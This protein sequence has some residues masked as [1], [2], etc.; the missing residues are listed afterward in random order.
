MLGAPR[1][2]EAASYTWNVT[3]GNW[4]TPTSW[5]PTTTG[6]NGPLATDTVMFA[7]NGASA[8]STTVNNIV[9]AG[10]AGTVS[11][12]L[13]T[14][15]NVNTFQV[16]QIG[17]G[18][19]L[20]VSNSVGVGGFFGLQINTF[21]YLTGGGNLVASGTTNFT[22][23]NYGSAS[24][25]GSQGTLDLS[26][27][28]TF[29]YNNPTG[30]ISIA[31]VGQSGFTR[32][33]GTL[34]LAG[35][36]NNITAA[37]INVGTCAAAQ[38]GPNDNFYLGAGTNIINVGTINLANNK[39]SATNTFKGLT[40]GLKIRGVTGVDTDRANIILGNR[41]QSGTGT[42]AGSM[43]FNGY[44]V[45]IKANA[46]IVGT[47][48]S[49]GTTGDT[50]TGVFQF[51]T[52]TVD[53]TSVIIGA[54]VTALGA[55]NGTVTV[56]ANGT[57]VVGAGGLSLVTQTASGAATGNLNI[58]NGTVVCNGSISVATNAGNSTIT[59]IG[60]GKLSL[61]PGSFVGSLALPVGNLILDTNS[62][63][64][65]SVPSATRTNIVV[66][67]LTWPTTDSALT[68]NIVAVPA[69]LTAGYRH[70]AYSIRLDERRSIYCA[71][72]P[73]AARRC[74]QPVAGWQHH[75]ADD[76]QRR[77]LGIGRHQS[78]GQPRF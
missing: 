69:G 55:A 12:L 63:L 40:G 6:P 58:S 20:T 76:Y 44:P 56:G 4:S 11:T 7:T 48:F 72:A 19:T 51:D 57:L 1:P 29:I 38:A 53:A 34:V 36:S 54:S 73:H 25:T 47:N 21:A 26:G 13:Y 31:D 41:N 28:S 45:D 68:F 18:K 74:R 37:T 64:Q 9:D 46:L 35:V 71:R 62:T 66:N 59:F 15:T 27:L 22:V 43:F 14:S 23:E 33:G 61:N 78:I 65:F 5:T 39:N 32:A 77:S 24:G 52:G 42:C 2:A 16:T 70:S 3:S 8:S 30:T 75:L 10:F 60:G 50:G 49:S 17:P 67:S